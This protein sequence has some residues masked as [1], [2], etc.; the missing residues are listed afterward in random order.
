MLLSSHS[1][2][3]TVTVAQLPF[4]LSISMM[5]KIVSYIMDEADEESDGGQGSTANAKEAYKVFLGQCPKAK[6][7]SRIPFYLLS[8]VLKG[9]TH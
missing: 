6:L 8:Q 5:F 7:Y 2:W 1:G 9:H 4:P 3:P